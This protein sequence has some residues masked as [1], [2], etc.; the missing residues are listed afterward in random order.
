MFVK[1]EA[2]NQP[3]GNWNVSKVKNMKMMF[4]E[5]KSFKQI[6]PDEWK[7]EA[8]FYMEGESRPGCCTIA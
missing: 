2:F 5:A 8:N 4:I 6:L 7:K 3:I 1:S